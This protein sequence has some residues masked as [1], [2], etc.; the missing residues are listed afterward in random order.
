MNFGRGR[1]SRTAFRVLAGAPVFRTGTRC[2]CVAPS[3][4]TQ[5]GIEPA[6][7]CFADR[8][9]TVLATASYIINLVPGERFELSRLSALVS[10]TNVSAVPPPGHGGNGEIRTLYWLVWN[11]LRFQSRFIPITWWVPQDLNLY[12]HKGQLVLQTSSTIRIGLTP[13]STNYQRSS[14][15]VAEG[16]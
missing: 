16:A 3:M 6:I 12:C 1:Q 11:Q 15:R 4:E 5:A 2:R 9:L 10:K 14:Y 7:I 8:C 13:M